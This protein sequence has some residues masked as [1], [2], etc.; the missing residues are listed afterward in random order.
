MSATWQRSC[1]HLLCRYR[2]LAGRLRTRG[3]DLGR[4]GSA[5]GGDRGRLQGACPPR[6]AWFAGGLYCGFA[7]DGRHDPRALRPRR[8]G[9]RRVP[10]VLTRSVCRLKSQ[11]ARI[12]RWS[13]GGLFDVMRLRYL[14][15][16][17][18]RIGHLAFEPDAFIKEGLLGLR[19]RY[20]GILCVPDSTVANPTLARYW[21]PYFLT[22]FSPRLCRLVSGLS[23]RIGRVY[24]VTLYGNTV[25][26]T[27]GYAAIQRQ[28]QGRPPLL[29]LTDEDR[30]RGWECLLAFGVPTNAW[31]V[32]FHTRE[33]GYATHDDDLHAYRNSDISNYLAAVRS[34]VDRGGWCIRMG[35]GSMKPLPP[36]ERVID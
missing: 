4:G 33:A 1:E 13:V 26:L 3:E 35:D 34:I 30:R 21:K 24:D 32:C 14:P 36:M 31:F 23:T 29:R 25:N 28:W 18:E 12:V 8:P 5:R 2:S 7:R 15:V 20:R 17:V 9:R 16:L 22:L 27:A 10:G 11:L 6:E 19:P